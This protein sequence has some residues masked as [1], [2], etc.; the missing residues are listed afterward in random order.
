MSRHH[1]LP[2]AHCT[3]AALGSVATAA[4]LE[5][6]YDPNAHSTLNGRALHV[7]VHVPNNHDQRLAAPDG[8]ADEERTADALRPSGWPH[9]QWG[10]E[11]SGE[12]R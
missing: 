5:S 10:H 2:L 7:Y 11:R 3:R 8:S 1:L 12:G 4:R 6:A 9:G